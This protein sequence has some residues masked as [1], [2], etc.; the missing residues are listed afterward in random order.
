M[1]RIENKARRVMIPLITGQ[2]TRLSPANQQ[3]V[4]MWAA[5]K[6]MVAEYDVQGHV[7]THHTQRK[8]M[9]NSQSIS[10]TTWTVWIGNYVRKQWAISYFAHPFN[11]LSDKQLARSP[12]KVTTDHFNSNMSTQVIG[13]LFIEV[14]RSPAR[15]FIN[16]W[17]FST[18]DKGSLYRIWPPAG[19]SITW[20]GRTMSDRDADYVATALRDFLGRIVE[21]RG[22]RP[23][24]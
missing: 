21:K 1:R 20:P 24:S 22:R 4:A 2:E 7:T 8:R 10:D 16:G 15:R 11:H 13:Q 18:P 9:M 19:F 6:A 17:R 12:N 3:V 23:R 14:I 5:L